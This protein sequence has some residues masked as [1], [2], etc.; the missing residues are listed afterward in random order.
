LRTE[1][2]LYVEYPEAERELYDLR[3]DPFELH[4][5]HAA[6]TPSLRDRLSRRLAALKA[7]AGPTCRDE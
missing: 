6:A 5:I 3:G 2:Y 7:C 4:S 1:E